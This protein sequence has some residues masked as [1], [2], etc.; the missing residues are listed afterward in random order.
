MPKAHQQ[1]DWGASTLSR[2]QFAYAAA[3][4][5]LCRRLWMKVACE[6]KAKGR[7]R[8]YRLQRN[9][10]AA[11][12]A[13]KLRGIAIDLDEHAELYDRWDID[14]ADARQAWVEATDKSPP[15]KPADA[16][17]YL[18]QA[19]SEAAL[20]R[21]PRTDATGRLSTAGEQLEKVA[22]L[23]T[24]RPLLRIKKAEKL[25]SAFGPKLRR[26]VNPE[27]GGCTRT[28]TSPVPR[29][30][31]GPQ[32]SRT[33]SSCRPTQTLAASSSPARPRARGRRLLAD[34]VTSR[35]LDKGMEGRHG[36]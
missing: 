29:P 18:E 33:S 34:G 13:M 20:S 15:S 8:A 2:G 22:H 36:C 6:L 1:S 3:D 5:V 30:A 7:D 10:L 25:L 12:A 9:C 26:L 4:A 27:E 11:A 24:I 21:W 23:P 19:L 28:T 31:A 17:Q 35:R 32:A 14:L 16:A